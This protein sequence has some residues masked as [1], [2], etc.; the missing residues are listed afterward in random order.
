MY[1]SGSVAAS[2]TSSGVNLYSG[3]SLAASFT[4]SGVELYSGSTTTAKF[5]SGKMYIG[6]SYT[7]PHTEIW[8]NGMYFYSSSSSM[9]GSITKTI[10]GY[11]EI[12]NTARININAPYIYIP[13]TTV[14]VSAD[15]EVAG[16]IKSTQAG[17]DALTIDSGYIKNA[18]AVTQAGS[19]TTNVHIGSAGR[20][21]AISGS[22]KRWK[23]SIERIKEESLDP[24]HLYDVDVVQF[25]FNTDYIKNPNDQR[26][27]T[28]VPGFIAE[29]LQKVY[30][31][32]VDV[33]EETGEVMDW[34]MKMVVPPMLALIQEQKKE[35]DS[36]REELDDI[37][38]LIA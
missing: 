32:A 3:S 5:S 17:G 34:N 19:Y 30:P 7:G 4:S 36:I 18:Y 35:I 6:T 27:D 22:S 21:F 23:N 15:F 28:L 20:F 25:K 31:I 13:A 16:P 12:Y 11:V 29:D 10:S 9:T 26:Y 2:F 33:D 1:A 38:K 14:H 37:K 8:N 24:H